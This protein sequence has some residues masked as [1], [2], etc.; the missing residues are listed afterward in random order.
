MAVVATAIPSHCAAGRMDEEHNVGETLAPTGANE[1]VS[2][3][4]RPFDTAMA[5]DPVSDAPDGDHD[6]DG[7]EEDAVFMSADASTSHKRKSIAN[8]PACPLTTVMWTQ[9]ED[10]KKGSFATKTELKRALQTHGGTFH[11]NY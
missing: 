5:T 7:I 6:H 10:A 8:R 3:K 2:W 9:Q 1:S 4:K 11:S